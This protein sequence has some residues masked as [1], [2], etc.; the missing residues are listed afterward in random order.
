[1]DTPLHYREGTLADASA[2]R[3][4]NIISYSEFAHVLAAAEW[5]K[6]NANLHNE[7]R[8]I[9]LIKLAKTFVCTSGDK[10]VGM[11]FFVPRGNPTDIYQDDWCYIRMLGIDPAF[12]GQGIARELTNRCIAYARQVN[13]PAIMLHTSE[14]MPAA[15][16]IYE[17]MGFRIFKDIGLIFGKQYWLYKLDL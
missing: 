3:E 12:R 17:S 14:M 4:L 15:R 1:M 10:I 7:S 8:I 13:E 9:E 2:L 16:H 11:A 5:A 6:M